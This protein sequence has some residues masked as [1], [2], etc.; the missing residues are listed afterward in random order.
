MSLLQVALP[1]HKASNALPIPSSDLGIVP[2]VTNLE[3]IPLT[4]TEK[5]LI[6]LVG[7]LLVI[8]ILALIYS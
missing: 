4:L 3:T 6:F 5:I 8:L 7:L 1:E 2:T